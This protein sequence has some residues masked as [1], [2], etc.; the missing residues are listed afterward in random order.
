MEIFKP[1]T[2]TRPGMS[3]D[4]AVKD[5]LTLFGRKAFEY[6]VISLWDQDKW[7]RIAAANALAD[8]Q[9]IRSYQF[10]V[11]LLN[12]TDKDIRFAAAVS[13]GKLGDARA[14]GPLTSAC[15]DR[16]YYVREGAK[17]SL[18]ILSGNEGSGFPRT[19]A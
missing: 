19:M 18:D 5:M 17:H 7:V 15:N 11:A 4:N 2:G 3:R 10:L 16:N 1:R 6:L 9:D 14:V 12:D 13:L 8:L